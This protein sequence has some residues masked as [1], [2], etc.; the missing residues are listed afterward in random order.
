[1]EI[2]SCK[3]KEMP[4]YEYTPVTKENANE[5]CDWCNGDTLMRRGNFEPVF[6]LENYQAVYYYDVI[7][8][9]NEGR[10]IA[11]HHDDFVNKFDF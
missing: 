3:F 2:R 10:F 1:M 5:V 6:Y 9:I 8:K 11:F 4:H 7:V